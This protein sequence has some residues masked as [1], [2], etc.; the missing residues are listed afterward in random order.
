MNE[1]IYPIKGKDWDMATL[2]LT[3]QIKRLGNGAM[4]S[5]HRRDM[6]E[7]EA[8]VG[9][10]VRVTVEK[11]DDNYE[12]TRRSA[13]RMRQRFARTLDLLGQ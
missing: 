7:I 6:E 2:T 3:R 11:V 13:A 1:C 5:I 8:Q 4:V 10:T 9:S 12:A